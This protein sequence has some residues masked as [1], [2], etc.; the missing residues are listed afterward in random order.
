[1]SIVNL[2]SGGLDSTVMAVLTKE[3]GMTQFPLFIDYGQLG[4]DKELQAC[5]MNFKRYGLPEPK[6]APL[7]GYGGL[8]SSGLTDPNKHILKEA[9][10]PCRNLMFLT[11]GAAYAFQ[12]G[13]S[14]VGIGLLDEAF[15]LFPDQTKSFLSDAEAL[16]SKALGKSIRVITPL[17]TFSK[18]DVLRIAKAKGITGTYSC[19]AGTDVP[20]GQCVACREYI[21]LEV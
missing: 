17:I 11:V 3:E 21:G 2:V 19:H 7:S 18:A 9:F 15:S 8:L 1:M 12:C 10:L 20:C 13:A 5:Q 4:R 6:M 14:A 16:L